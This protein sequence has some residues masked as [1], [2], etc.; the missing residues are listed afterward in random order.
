MIYV[1]YGQPGSGKTTLGKL[2]ADHLGTPFIIDG[3]EFR[4]MFSNINYSREGREENLRGAN[5]VATYLSK[6][7]Q[8]EGHVITSLVNPYLDIR[9]ELKRNNKGCVTEVCLVSER[10]LR[11]EH[12]VKDFEVGNPHYVMGTDQEVEDGWRQLRGLLDV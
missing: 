12:H 7:S 6:K 8:P 1:L 4:K 11:K 9:N 2:L 3:D 10:D 5:A